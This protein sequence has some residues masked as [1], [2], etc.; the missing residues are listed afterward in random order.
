MDTQA[1]TERLK[2]FV[3]EKF[4]LAKMQGVKS[5]DPLLDGG[6]IDSLGILDLVTFLEKEFGIHVYDEELL[7][8]NFVTLDALTAFIQQKGSNGAQL[9][10]NQ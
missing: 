1:L 7:S 9:K 6:I 10:S 3:Y 2:D 5:S 4:P 8:E